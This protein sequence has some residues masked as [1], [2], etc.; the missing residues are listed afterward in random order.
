MTGLERTFKMNTKGGPMGRKSVSLKID[1]DALRRIMRDHDL[2]FSDRAREFGISKQALN[3]WMSCNRMPARALIE[4]A[5][6]VKLSREQVD[7]ILVR[8]D[9]RDKE[10]NNSK[11]IWKINIEVEELDDEQN[12]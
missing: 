7:E 2:V 12:V 10:K 5:I 1:G 3:G 9:I 8:T 6:D 4:L 11:K